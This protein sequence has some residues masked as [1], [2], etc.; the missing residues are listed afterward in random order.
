VTSE[1]PDSSPYT[2]VRHCAVDERMSDDGTMMGD[3][4]AVKVVRPDA[5]LGD[6]VRILREWKQVH[7]ADAGDDEKSMDWDWKVDPDAGITLSIDQAQELH[8]ALS[9]GLG[10]PC[11]SDREKAAEYVL[12]TL[13]DGKTLGVEHVMMLARALAECATDGFHADLCGVCHKHLY[14]CDK[15][16]VLDDFPDGNV[17]L[18]CAGARARQMLK[19]LPTRVE[20]A[21]R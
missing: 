4:I 13:Q 8:E 9:V 15:E 19:S 7:A 10:L 18:E 1:A 2:F 5:L 16:T 21:N 14:E 12:H 6:T 11:A 20:N 3:R 17:S